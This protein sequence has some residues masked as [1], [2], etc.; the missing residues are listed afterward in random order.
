MPGRNIPRPHSQIELL[1]RLHQMADSLLA[2]GRIAEALS[3]Y[4]ET[5]LGRE[6]LLGRDHPDTLTTRSHSGFA[7]QRLAT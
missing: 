4:T 5:L 1:E 3:R 2:E 6:R 7:Y